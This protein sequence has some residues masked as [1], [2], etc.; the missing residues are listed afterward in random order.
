MGI[1]LPLA[2]VGGFCGLDPADGHLCLEVFSP[3]SLALS[4]YRLDI[5][6]GFDCHLPLEGGKTPMALG[7]GLIRG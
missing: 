5:S 6:R 4:G 1:A 7:E 2:G 3:A